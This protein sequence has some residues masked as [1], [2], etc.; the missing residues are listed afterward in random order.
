[1]K[2]PLFYNEIGLSAAPIGSDRGL[3]PPVSPGS[4]IAGYRRGLPPPRRTLF[5]G[6]GPKK[7]VAAGSEQGSTAEPYSC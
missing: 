4:S 5:L 1:M 2:S 7:L 3:P 6:S